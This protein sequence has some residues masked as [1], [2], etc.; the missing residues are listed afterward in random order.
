MWSCAVG[1]IF[2]Y[3]TVTFRVWY[4]GKFAKKVEEEKEEAPA[5]K[6][7]PEADQA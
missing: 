1:L 6:E 2:G 3:V 5:T 7:A 4:E